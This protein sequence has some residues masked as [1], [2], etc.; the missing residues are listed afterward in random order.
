MVAIRSGDA[1]RVINHP[2]AGAYLYLVFGSDSGLV[3]ERIRTIL[4]ARGRRSQP[5]A[6]SSSASPATMS[7]PT[8]CAS[9]TRPTRSRCSAAARQS[10]SRRPA[11]R[12]SPAVELIL[13][14]PP[15]DCVIAFEGG[16]L[17]RDQ[18]H[19]QALRTRAG[20]GWPSS[21]SPTAPR[22]VAPAH[23]PRARRFGPHHRSRCQGAAALPA[24]P[25]PADHA[26]GTGKARH[27]RLRGRPR[28]GSITS[29]RSSPMRPRWCS[30]MRSTARSRARCAAIETTTETS[31][32]RERATSTM[33]LGSALRHATALHRARIAMDGGGSGD[34]GFYGA[35]RA[36]AEQ[37]LRLWDAAAS[38]ADR[39]GSRRRHRPRPPRAA[40]CPAHRHARSVGGAL[41]RRAANATDEPARGHEKKP[42]AS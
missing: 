16:A 30:T 24:R 17:K 26:L 7:P 9:S 40:P 11:S 33:L 13:R 28:D 32:R 27:L 23:R 35:R 21:V 6:S 39:R 4:V 25:G 38:R 15:R 20:R 3:A 34:A 36:A 12:C 37:Q 31:F 8:R 41:T 18:S 2:P 29:R 42:P 22:D 10:A 1:D 14:A 19:A 5:M